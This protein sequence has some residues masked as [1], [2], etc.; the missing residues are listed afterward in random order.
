MGV[1]LP[2]TVQ[3]NSDDCDPKLFG[4]YIIVLLNG[5]DVILDGD[6]DKASEIKL[7]RM[8]LTDVK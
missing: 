6:N 5:P 7:Q 4:S 3:E 1:G 8:C 2:A